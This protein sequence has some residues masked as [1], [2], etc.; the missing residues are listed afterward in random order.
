MKFGEKLFI[1]KI[2]CSVMFAL[3][4]MRI[5]HRSNVMSTLVMLHDVTVNMP[6]LS[7]T[8]LQN[9]DL[10]NICILAFARIAE[11]NGK[12]CLS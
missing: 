11:V 9:K 2:N 5:S 8:N 1:D 7:I 10:Q 12:P 4:I 6:T 3:M